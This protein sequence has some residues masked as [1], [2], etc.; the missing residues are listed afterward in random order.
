MKT[1]KEK[2]I[3]KTYL[4]F[5]GF[6]VF[7]GHRVYLEKEMTALIFHLKVNHKCWASL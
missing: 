3:L 6:G 2:S 7:G 1:T 5:L 4:L